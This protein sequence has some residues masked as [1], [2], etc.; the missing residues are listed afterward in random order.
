MTPAQW[1][2]LAAAHAQRERE[3][4]LF[5]VEMASKLF[6]AER[7]MLMQLIGS[8]ALLPEGAPEG[9]YIPLITALATDERIKSFK[10]VQQGG[11]MSP[12]KERSF[13]DS[14]RARAEAL[15]G[16]L[17]ANGSIGP[18]PALASPEGT[19]GAPTDEGAFDFDTD[20]LAALLAPY[21]DE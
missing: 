9:Q 16:G 20:K 18:V 10:E 19:P 1:A 3:Q 2:W 21:L 5:E 12:E 11:N 4:R 14:L 17:P 13:L 8:K 7:E 6:E 15:G